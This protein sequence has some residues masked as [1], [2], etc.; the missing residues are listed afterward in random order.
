[1]KNLFLD[2]DGVL[3]DSNR[4]K[5]SALQEVATTFLGES[6]GEAILNYHYA[7]P[8]FSRFDLFQQICSEFGCEGCYDV[9]EM[10]DV[11]SRNVM[12]GY[13]DCAR[14]SDST[15]RNLSKY[16][17]IVLSAAPVVEI[18]ELIELFGWGSYLDARVLGSPGRKSELLLKHQHGSPSL[19]GSLF[20][21]DSESDFRVAEEFGLGFVFVSDW[22]AWTPPSEDMIRFAAR[23]DSLAELVELPELRSWVID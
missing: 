16:S 13:L 22:S 3:V 7:N 23:V 15:L 20:V 17:P 10:L 4:L 1:M 9:P 2:F 19:E 21:G 14:V 6:A 12:S 8:G 11:F 18:L 5:S